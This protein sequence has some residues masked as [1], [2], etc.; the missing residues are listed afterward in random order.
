MSFASQVDAG[1][2]I[3]DDYLNDCL[4]LQPKGSDNM[5]RF[6]RKTVPGS[7]GRFYSCDWRSVGAELA[8]VATVEQNM[9]PFTK[10]EMER[11]RSARGLMARM[12]FPSVAMAMSIVNSG[13]NFDVSAHDFHVAEAIW[14][15]L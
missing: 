1:A 9:R 3:R 14:G 12:G 10:R 4:T 11:A 5:H 6:G 7:E 2:N 15:H 13:S 8:M